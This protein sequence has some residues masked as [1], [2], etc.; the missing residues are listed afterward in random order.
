MFA[1]LLGGDVRIGFENNI[2]RPDGTLA[3]SNAEAVA[4]MSEAIRAAGLR[5]ASADDLRNR[6]ALTMN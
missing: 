1:A 5:V 3:A 6:W 4:S 2:A